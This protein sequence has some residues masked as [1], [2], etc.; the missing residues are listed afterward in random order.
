MKKKNNKY[1]S[2]NAINSSDVVIG[3]NS[4]MLSEKISIGGK[5]LSCNFTKS[6]LLDFAIKSYLFLNKDDYLI[7]ENRLKDILKVSE[8]KFFSNLKSKKNFL[9]ES[10]NKINSIKAIK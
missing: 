10:H 9:I 8:K 5:I 6:K 1:S 4:T 3:V 2:Y 7:F